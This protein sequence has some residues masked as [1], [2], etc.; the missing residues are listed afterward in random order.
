MQGVLA[1]L[2]LAVSVSV[3][4]SQQCPRNGQLCP[5]RM[6]DF[7]TLTITTDD[8]NR[9]VTSTGCPP[10]PNPNWSNPN[11]ACVRNT[12]Y[13]IP[14][15]PKFSPTPV[16][17]GE[18]LSRFDNILYLKEYPAPIF[19]AIGVLLNGVVV[20]GRGSPCGFGSRCPDD[21]TGAPSIY[22]DA[23]DS[24]GRTIDQC[25]GHPQMMGEYH[26][27]SGATFLNNT[28]REMCRL[29]VD[30]PGN[31]SVLLGWMFDGFP[32]YGQYSQEGELPTALDECHG[33]THEID[34]V[35]T[36]H[37]HMPLSYPHIIGC[38]KGC[39]VAS[40]NQRQLG[41]LASQYCANGGLDSDPKPLYEGPGGPSEAE[42]TSTAYG[43]VAS[44][45]AVVLTAL[46][47][48]ILLH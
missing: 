47:S 23:V 48:F 20:Y 35:V 6:E 36:Y 10:Y 7:H 45:L 16:P 2:V 42:G 9:Y 33:H 28:G 11:S 34:G 46:L 5:T 29:P 21:G 12:T 15:R 43:T 3:A 44:V 31:H 25:G 8:T 17:V 32:M 18:E 19:G 13:T 39:P 41:G 37:Y 24:E 1:V 38:F 30:T 14:M 27:H 40:N 22:V 26:I 4:M